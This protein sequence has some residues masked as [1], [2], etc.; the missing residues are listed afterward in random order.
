MTEVVTGIPTY[1]VPTAI[2]GKTAIDMATYQKMYKQS[3]EDP[4]NFWAEQAE[5]F[6][7]WYKKWD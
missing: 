4:Q 3:V 5:K 6:V 2:Q 7:T 1:P